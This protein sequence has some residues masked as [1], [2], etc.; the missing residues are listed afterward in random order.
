[1]I[2]RNVYKSILNFKREKYDYKSKR[3]NKFSVRKWSVHILQ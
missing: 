2:L 1:M 3:Y